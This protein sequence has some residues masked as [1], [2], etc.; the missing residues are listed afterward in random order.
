[1]RRGRHKQEDLENDGGIK[2]WF[3][4]EECRELPTLHRMGMDS[5]VLMWS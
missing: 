5:T 1:M 2:G 3:G 4:K